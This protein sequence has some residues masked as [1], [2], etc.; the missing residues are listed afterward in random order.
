MKYN[1]LQKYEATVRTL[2]NPYNFEQHQ[3][4]DMALRINKKRRFLFV[5]QVL[6]K[7][8][9]VDPSIPLLTSHLLAYQFMEQ[10]YG[11]VSEFTSTISSAI[12]TKQNLGGVLAASQSIKLTPMSALTVI[13]FAETATALGHGFFEKFDGDVQFVHTTREHIVDVEPI[14]CFEEEH[15]HASSHRVYAN[16]QFFLRNAEVVLIDDE[17]TTGKTNRN[18]IRQLYEK[19]PHLKSFTLVSILDFRTKQA[20]LEMQQMAHELGITIHCVSLFTGAF[21]VKETGALFNEV[22]FA[23]PYVKPVTN[24][25]S[26]EGLLSGALLEQASF[27]EFK[28]VK[29]AN[30]YRDSGRF[31]L[32]IDGQQRLEEHVEQ[33]AA[34]LKQKRSNGKCLVL[35][36]GEFMYVPMS[37]AVQMGDN[38]KYHAT[39]RSPIYSHENSHIYNK[40]TFPSAEFPGVTNHLYNIPMNEYTD[41]FVIYERI[42]DSEAAEVLQ[43]QLQPYAN[44]IH[45]VTLGGVGNAV[46]T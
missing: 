28:Q 32:S 39:T 12:R 10:R 26:F 34:S 22:V 18:I 21:Q 45:F 13:G 16:E 46:Y 20:Q 11:Y 23:G 44:H 36:T 35:G 30:Y 24:E 9:A 14:I 7:H 8:L 4:F 31:A 29:N 33:I 3:L 41:I 17:M 42:M 27:C 19:Y 37:I 6:G 25:Y 43:A 15:S 1:V 40:F 2:D 5:S 38:V